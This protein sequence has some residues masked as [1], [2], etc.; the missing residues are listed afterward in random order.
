V[1]A[2]GP[3]RIQAGRKEASLILT[4]SADAPLEVSGFRV[5]GTATIDGKP[6]RRPA[7]ARE[8]LVRNN[9]KR[10]RPSPLPTAAA[11]E[12]ADMVVS[13]TPERLLLAPGQ[14][15]EIA[16]KVERGAGFKG[17]VP[18]AVLGLPE[19]V[20]ADA[21]DI[22]EDKAEGKIT[23]KAGGEVKPGELEIVVA[24]RSVIDDQRQVLH[25]APPIVLTVPA[26]AEKR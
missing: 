1:S 13:A 3:T 20:S 8:E 22:A 11:S 26:A 2:I 10:T 9:E 16:V 23:L 18:L 25:A 17:K 24:G 6:V 12:L 7:E 19:G 5:V 4:A 21:P 14:S 15:V